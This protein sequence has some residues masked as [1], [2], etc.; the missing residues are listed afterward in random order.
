MPAHETE[1]GYCCA[2][3]Y[4]I[5]QL[6]KELLLQ[7]QSFLEELKALRESLGEEVDTQNLDTTYGDTEHETDAVYYGRN[8]KLTE[9]RD[10][11]SLI[12]KKYESNL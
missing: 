8:E 2:C 12:I 3:P 7:K 11:I 5:M 1:D 4:D 6:K 10:I 9:D